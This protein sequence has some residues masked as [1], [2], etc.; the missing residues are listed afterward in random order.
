MDLAEIHQRQRR[1]EELLRVASE[2]SQQLARELLLLQSSDWQFLMTTGQA[3]DYAV[4]RFRSHEERF[5]SLATA[6]ETGSP[7]LGALTTEYGALDNPF[8]NIN[9]LAYG[10]RTA[11]ASLRL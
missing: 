2:A 4:E 9:P 10:S 11:G 7:G 5:D 8:P 3:H 6:I 1:A